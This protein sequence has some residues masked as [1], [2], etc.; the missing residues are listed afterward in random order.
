MRVA[1]RGR[2]AI[3]VLAAACA[4]CAS[5]GRADQVEISGAHCQED[6]LKKWYCA[7]DPKGTAVI[8]S[9]GRAL[10]APGGCVKQETQDTKQEWLCSSLSGGRAVAVP[11][12]PPECDGKCRA[13]EAT[14]CKQL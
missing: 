8:D 3:P 11:A 13:P 2:I 9:L 10:C 4:V 5:A 14:A 7:A 12:G 6:A 1:Q